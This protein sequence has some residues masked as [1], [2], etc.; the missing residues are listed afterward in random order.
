MRKEQKRWLSPEE[1]E[2]EF[3]ISMSTQAKMR[4]SGKIPF[5]KIGGFVRYDR[6]KID[7]WF[8]KHE[9]SDGGLI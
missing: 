3:G 9:I 6:R 1:L 7:K 8:E 4:M 5:S 2:S